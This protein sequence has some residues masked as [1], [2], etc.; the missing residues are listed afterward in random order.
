MPPHHRQPQERSNGAECRPV[1]LSV[2]FD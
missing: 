2:L 1:S